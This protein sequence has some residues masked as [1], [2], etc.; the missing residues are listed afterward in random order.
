[1]YLLHIIFLNTQCRCSSQNNRRMRSILINGLVEII[2]YSYGGFTAL[3]F[4]SIIC[5]PVLDKHVWFYD[6]SIECLSLWQHIMSVVC[7]TY[8]LPFPGII[9]VGMSLLKLRGISG[10]KFLLGCFFPLP[11]LIHWSCLLYKIKTATVFSVTADISKIDLTKN[12]NLPD[13]DDD[14]DDDQIAMFDRFRGGYKNGEYGQEYWES[15]M[16]LRRLLLSSTILIP[17]PIMQLATCLVFSVLFFGHHM[18][19]SPFMHKISNKIESLSLFFLCIISGI[20]LI[21]ANYLYLG[22]SPDATNTNLTN[23]LS[24]VETMFL[25]F[26][27]AFVILCEM[28]HEKDNRRK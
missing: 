14:N 16:I 1:M 7:I 10:T 3:V 2:K 24:L 27:F 15:I 20:N 25:P 28:H 6:G 11:C 18:Y 4:Y 9:Y 13:K 19:I 8:V 12:R 21:K 22:I 23:N 26:L 17:N 5:V